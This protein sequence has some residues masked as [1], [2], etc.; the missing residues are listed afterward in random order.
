M[1]VQGLS[2]HW[3]LLVVALLLTSAAAVAITRPEIPDPGDDP[4]L[5]SGNDSEDPE[6]QD[7]PAEADGQAIEAPPWWPP[8]GHAPDPDPDRDR[9]VDD[10]GPEDDGNT[11]EEDSEDRSPTPMEPAPPMRFGM[12]LWHLDLQREHGIDPDL[13]QTWAGAW[14]L[15]QGWGPID[16]HLEAARENNITPVIQVFYWGNDLS[17]G[18]LQNGCEGRGGMELSEAGWARLL[19]QLGDRLDEKLDGREAVVVLEPEF[20]K[21]H[22]A[23]YEPLDAMLAD[24]ALQMKAAYPNATVALG[25]GG[26]A[27]QFWGTWDRAMEASDV[28]SVQLMRGATVDD[29][30]T[31]LSSA[32]TLAEHAERAHELSGKPVLVTDIALATWPEP[33]YRDEQDQVV[34]DLLK[35]ETMSRLKAAHVEGIIYRAIIDEPTATTAEYYGQ[36]ET[37]W[38]LVDE[39]GTPKP[40]LETWVQGIQ[41][42]RRDPAPRPAS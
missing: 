16:K 13:G 35:D 21:G 42:E 8:A 26:W 11:S 38:G 33:E 25:L 3:P 30:D 41:E 10:R 31:Y 17:K 20:N 6:A 14:N 12:G 1:P 22:V 18:C 5:L 23:T 7:T 32:E 9:S 4:P 40:A 28:I 19:D 24:R 37:T 15:Y 39:D 27:P 2:S 29:R 34:G 36:A